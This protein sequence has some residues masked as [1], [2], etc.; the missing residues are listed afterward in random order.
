MPYNPDVSFFIPFHGL[1]L[2]PSRKAQCIFFTLK[3][4]RCRNKCKESDKMQAI[5]LR[6]AINSI[7]SEAVD[8]DLL[9]DCV[10]YNCCSGA[11]HRNKIEDAELLTPLAQRW[12]SE[13]RRHFNRTISLPEHRSAVINTG[14]YTSR[15]TPSHN[16]TTARRG[17]IKSPDYYQLHDSRSSS[18][19]PTPSKPMRSSLHYQYGSSSGTTK[20]ETSL[21][22]NQSRYNLRPRNISTNSTSGQISSIPQSPRSEFRPHIEN[23]RPRDSVFHKILN[24]IKKKSR[25]DETG[26]VYIFDRMSSHGYVKIG[27]T[28][29]SVAD[30]LAAWSKCG[31]IPNLLF[32]INNVPHARRVET[33]THYEL[34]KEWRR[35]RICKACGTSHQEWFEV[36]QG[37]A[38]QVLNN[39]ADFM[40]IAEP[41]DSNGCLKSQ[42]QEAVRNIDRNGEL[43]TG[44]KLL[45]RHE[46]ITQRQRNVDVRPS[47]LV[48]EISERD[49]QTRRDETRRHGQDQSTATLDDLGLR[50]NSSNSSLILTEHQTPRS[51]AETT[52]K[53]VDELCRE[54]AARSATFDFNGLDLRNTLNVEAP[55]AVGAA[56]RA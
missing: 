53:I 19:S 42:W 10:L 30:R 41:Y 18:M 54:F 8:L 52:L 28:A 33:L 23:P 55:A 6:N 47:E 17:S 27:W 25:D 35:E 29:R 49:R 38:K 51:L 32:S 2:D 3:G 43:V 46:A 26:S 9:Q 44:K 22:G 14:V 11:R 36:D 20:V 48:N 21:F 34:I 50:A 40:R 12:Q 45:E 37:R 16:N 24:P 7:S 1:D 31:Y 39:W 13:I 15:S 4:D 5:I 56:A